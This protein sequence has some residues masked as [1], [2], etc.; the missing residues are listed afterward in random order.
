MAILWILIQATE[1]G[2][3][4]LITMTVVAVK[5]EEGLI[6]I[7]LPTPATYLCKWAVLHRKHRK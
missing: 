5:Q 3:G 6:C 7:Y 4:L 2:F 1:V